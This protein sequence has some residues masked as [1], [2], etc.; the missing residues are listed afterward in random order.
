MPFDPI[1][2]SSLSTFTV[3]V[4]GA[5]LAET[6][7]VISI[8]IGREI[9]RVPYAHL[10]I[11][12]GD[13]AAQTF[14]ISEAPDIAPG[15]EIEILLGYDREESLVFSGVVTRH[16]I[17]APLHASSR[18]HVEAKHRCFRMAHARKSRIWTEV[19]D[20]DAL[21]DLAAL[22][23]LAFDGES[24]AVRPQLVQ[25]QA[26]DW[27]FAVMRAEM[28]GQALLA[29]NDGLKMFTPDPGAPPSMALEYGRTL[30]ALD[31]E[32]DAE[33]QPE[34]VE[35]G[36]WIPADQAV[37]TAEAGG[38]DVPG[39]GAA[40][41]AALATVS[42]QKPRPRHAGGRDQA[43]IDD[44]ARAETLR[45]RIAAIRGAAEIQGEAR[46]E[47]G[48]T[49]ELKGFGA[50]FNGRAFVSGLRHQLA[51]G[52]WRTSVQIG[53]DPRFH[54]ER[55]DI[56]APAAAGLAPAITGLQ[57]GIVD[58]LEGDP[59]GEER[60]A[61]RIA[62]ETETA[63]PIWARPLSIGGGASRGFVMLP[64]IGDE[65][66]LGFLDG[67]PRDPIL[68][69]GVH[70]AAAASPYPGADDNNLKGAASRAGV[71]ITFDDD[72]AALVAETPNGNRVTLSD[73][74]GGITLEDEA[75]NSITTGADGVSV[76]SPKDIKLSAT[77]DVTIEGLNVTL[78]A[79]VE[80][81]VQGSAGAK[82]DSSG[83]TVVKGSI[84]MIN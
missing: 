26:T 35:A 28:V 67:D 47:P 30:F 75:G 31:L 5:A 12:D 76:E 22:Q 59:A 70:S 54:R 68:L 10:V 6:V 51:N 69:G 74:D 33:A 49:V 13:P 63:E 45:R 55:F 2:S 24:A 21:S 23:G 29:T 81:A 52:D 41:G 32:I 17:E 18:L 34:S 1:P 78:K 77:G 42:N 46:L 37:A 20:A 48:A 36:A 43:E 80:A 44:W 73:A 19:T 66:L 61:V 14:A 40:D 4:G 56:D 72:S 82:V 25:H 53:L 8:E 84:V 7:G 62:T 60:V 57:I 16:R 3:K 65:C 58:A 9:G 27:D 50:R 71:K 83:Q 79:Q 15:V 38:E 11:Q 64:E 39:P